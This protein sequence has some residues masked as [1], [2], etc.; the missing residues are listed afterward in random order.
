MSTEPQP[1]RQT[2]RLRCPVCGFEYDE[3]VEPPHRRNW[4][5]R[6]CCKAA[7]VPKFAGNDGIWR[8]EFVGAVLD[9]KR[10]D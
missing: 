10:G 9:A 5:G 2:I 3:F 1:E 7:M 8:V 4:E 6:G